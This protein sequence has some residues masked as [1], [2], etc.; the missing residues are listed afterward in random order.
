MST[1]RR[2]S[3]I[4]VVWDYYGISIMKASAI[5]LLVNWVQDEADYHV[6]VAQCYYCDKIV[7]PSQ[8]DKN[9]TTKMWNH[10]RKSHPAEYSKAK[11]RWQPILV[12]YGIITASVPGG[13]LQSP[14]W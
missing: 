8:Y 11:S 13:H 4:S 1:T 12:S 5:P 7:L 2:Q 10:L 6:Q 14:C 3:N 9:C